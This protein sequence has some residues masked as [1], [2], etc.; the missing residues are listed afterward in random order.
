MRAARTALAGLAL[1]ALA[2]VTTASPLPPAARAEVN[3]LMTRMQTVG[4]DFNRNGSWYSGAD[5]TGH[6]LKKL[7]YFE[8]KDEVHSA[9]QFIERAATGSMM[10]GKPYLVRCTGKPTL[11][12]RPWLLGELSGIRAAR[13]APASSPR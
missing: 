6:L 1:S 8:G 4:C 5:A 3:A 11:E 13:S 10:S 2:A 7:D 12:M 9:E